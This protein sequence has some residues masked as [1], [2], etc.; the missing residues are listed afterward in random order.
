MEYG[1]CNHDIELLKKKKHLAASDGIE[2]YKWRIHYFQ[3]EII[4]IQEHNARRKKSK[5]EIEKIIKNNRKKIYGCCN[6]IRKLL[7]RQ[8]CDSVISNAVIYSLC[9]DLCS[10]DGYEDDAVNGNEESNEES[11]EDAVVN[12]NEEGNEVDAMNDVVNGNE[13]GDQNSNRNVNVSNDRA[14]DILNNT[15]NINCF[16][17]T[18]MKKYKR[19]IALLDTKVKIVRGMWFKNMKDPNLRLICGVNCR[20]EITC[21]VPVGENEEEIMTFPVKKCMSVK[22]RLDIIK[23]VMKKAGFHTISDRE[24]DYGY[25][26]RLEEERR[27]ELGGNDSQLVAKRYNT[28]GY[29][30]DYTT[31]LKLNMNNENGHMNEMIEEIIDVMPTF[32][33]LLNTLRDLY[34]VSYPRVMKSYTS[35]S[36]SDK[37]TLV[38][39]KD[40]MH[41]MSSTAFV[42]GTDGMISKSTAYRI[43]QN[44]SKDDVEDLQIL[45]CITLLSIC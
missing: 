27:N 36:F 6:G 38:M 2:K 39:K 18:A 12:D 31:Y 13:D 34:L 40:D 3:K 30:Y 16:D 44:I 1:E 8:G 9:N 20:N 14:N 37:S 26:E 11:N 35:F 41:T 4:K 33:G 23:T 29:R 10:D 45:R 32:N 25:V 42:R 22:G 19:G 24:S 21:I 43:I 28:R 5:K 7:A 17:D 15:G